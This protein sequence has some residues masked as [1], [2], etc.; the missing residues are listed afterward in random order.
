MSNRPPVLGK[1]PYDAPVQVVRTTPLSTSIANNIASLN[2]STW[3]TIAATSANSVFL[4]YQLVNVLWP[5]NN[6]SILAGAT[7]PL[8]DGDATPKQSQQPVANTVLET[9]HQN[10]NCLA[11]HTS[12]AV[13]STSSAR[14][15]LSNKR[16]ADAAGKASV[17]TGA[18]QPAL[19]S[20]YSFLFS[21]AQTT[22]PPRNGPVARP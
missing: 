15:S 5:N 13:A 20:D 22:A 18:S 10:L 14:Q 2:S 21:E 3:A 17:V 11:C 4:N 1:D 12:A 19:A 8:T 7:I 9:Y 16:P 6:T